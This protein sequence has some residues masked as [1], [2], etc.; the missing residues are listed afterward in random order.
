LLAPYP[1]QPKSSVHTYLTIQNQV[2]FLRCPL[3]GPNQH[4][5]HDTTRLYFQTV[6]LSE[7]LAASKYFPD[8]SITGNIDPSISYGCG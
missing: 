4:A 8:D 2:V 7:K 3:F 6:R 1:I 5:G